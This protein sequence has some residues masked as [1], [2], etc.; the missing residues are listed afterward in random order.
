M[1]RGLELH[2]PLWQIAQRLSPY[3]FVVILFVFSVSAGP[4]DEFPRT[5]SLVLSLLAGVGC[6]VGI[7]DS[8]DEDAGDV[9]GEKLGFLVLRVNKNFFVIF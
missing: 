2:R 6:C 3:S 7:A 9:G 1:R 8:C 4:R 5:P